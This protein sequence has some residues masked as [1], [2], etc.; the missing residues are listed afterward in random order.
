[1]LDTVKQFARQHKNSSHRCCTNVGSTAVFVQHRR[2]KTLRIQVA[3]VAYR[4]IMTTRT[5]KTYFS[6][7][8]CRWPTKPHAAEHT[9]SSTVRPI[10]RSN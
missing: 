7:A 9:G 6:R 1:M 8:H 2:Q 3:E 4:T 5:H 10:G